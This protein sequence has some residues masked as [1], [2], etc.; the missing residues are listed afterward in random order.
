MLNNE[1]VRMQEPVM[2]GGVYANTPEL[3]NFL[4]AT[5]FSV[6]QSY[7]NNTSMDLVVVDGLGF[8]Q[9]L[10]R[11]NNLHCN[12]S[13]CVIRE[14]VISKEYKEQ[15]RQFIKSIGE[16]ESFMLKEMASFVKRSNMTQYDGFG[17]T[18]LPHVN[19]GY[20]LYVLVEITEDK[21]RD[22]ENYDL[23]RLGFTLSRAPMDKAPANPIEARSNGHYNPFKDIKKH[24]IFSEFTANTHTRSATSWWTTAGGKPIKMV[25]TCRTDRAEGLYYDEYEETEQGAIII[26][27]INYKK[28]DEV[29]NKSE[30]FTDEH[31]AMIACDLERSEKQV[32]LE[33][34]VQERALKKE[35]HRYNVEEQVMKHAV[36]NT[37]MRNE[38]IVMDH[39]RIMQDHIHESLVIA[40]EIKQAELQREIQLTDK[41]YQLAEYNLQAESKRVQMKLAS[42]AFGVMA[43]YTK[44]QMG[45]DHLSAKFALELNTM[46]M[47]DTYEREEMSRKAEEHQRKLELNHQTHQT[48][49]IESQEKERLVHYRMKEENNKFFTSLFGS[50]KTFAKIFI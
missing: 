30:F 50:L 43:D 6:R 22:A 11:G 38:L 42:D 19:Y 9:T 13:F 36:N 21:L 15:F 47:K 46:Q 4:N 12:Q 20:R 41:K 10:P 35:M 32:E 34:K 24:H 48:S 40:E 14:Y 49:M 23:L 31:Y 16:Q 33:I 28:F 44:Q 29:D 39:K 7:V 3:E 45:L 17:E 25:N 37:R 2:L 26:R 5:R 8:R 27:T 1:A 18:N